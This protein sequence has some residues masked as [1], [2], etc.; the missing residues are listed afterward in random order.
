MSWWRHQSSNKSS[1]QGDV[2]V[3]EGS[4]GWVWIHCE[5]VQVWRF[6]I[7]I[8][9]WAS[10]RLASMWCF[11]IEF[12]G[13]LRVWL[14]IVWSQDHICGYLQSPTFGMEVCLYCSMHVLSLTLIFMVQRATWFW[15][16]S[17]CGPSW[18]CRCKISHGWSNSTWSWINCGICWGKQKETCRNES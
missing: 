17:I 2:S 18:C 5:E 11:I 3:L 16:C 8:N 7:S 4:E 14:I 13:V 10:T 15:V 12:Y 6:S 9:T 1:V